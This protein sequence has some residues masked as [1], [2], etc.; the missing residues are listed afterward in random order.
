MVRITSPGGCIKPPQL[1]RQSSLALNGHDTSNMCGIFIKPSYSF[2]SVHCPGIA[3][4]PAAG[5]PAPSVEFTALALLGHVATN[6]MFAGFMNVLSS[7]V[8]WHS[9]G[10]MCLFC[11]RLW[12]S[13]SIFKHLVSTLSSSTVLHACHPPGLSYIVR[14]WPRPDHCHCHC[15]L[16][17]P[18]QWRVSRSDL[19]FVV[20]LVLAFVAIR[21]ST[22]IAS[23]FIVVFRSRSSLAFPG[24]T[25]RG[26]DFGGCPLGPLSLED[27]FTSINGRLLMLKMLAPG[28]T[29]RHL[30]G[31]SRDMQGQI[32]K[33]EISSHSLPDA[34]APG[35]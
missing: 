5:T 23:M 21:V 32:Q 15:Q 31:I 9:I 19:T 8:V 20:V 10:I 33:L 30:F 28:R 27:T 35:T 2:C 34:G 16:S 12:F 13:C 6:V 26:E 29:V 18:L 22:F 4:V 17:W 3:V 7:I 1:P 24:W 14:R 11:W 25:S